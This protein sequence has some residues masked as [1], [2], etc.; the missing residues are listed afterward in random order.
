MLHQTK[1]VVVEAEAEEVH[2]LIGQAH[3]RARVGMIE[4]GELQ[5]EQLHVEVF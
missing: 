2:F 4:R 1:V 3:R 5:V